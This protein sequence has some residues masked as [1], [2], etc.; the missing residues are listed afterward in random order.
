MG[1][2]TRVDRAEAIAGYTDEPDE[3]QANAF[4][5]EFLMPRDA[6]KQWVAEHL[7]G[8]VTLETVVRF[9]AAFGVSAPAGCIRLKSVKAVE[10][11][12]YDRLMA[13]IGTGEH[14]GLV[15][16][17]GIATPA[18]TI[19]DASVPH[20]PESLRASALG[21]LLTGGMS[22]AQMAAS[23]ERPVAQVDAMLEKTGLGA[24]LPRSV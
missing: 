17:L 2:A 1:H 10:G 23:I 5:A 14:E 3:V 18:D 12:R 21:A 9:S 8:A 13:E 6:T 22:M 24:L 11:E 4:A 19:A 20:L 15:E 16:T 7:D